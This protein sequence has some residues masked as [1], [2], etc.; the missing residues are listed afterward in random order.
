MNRSLTIGLGWSS[1]A[2]TRIGVWSPKDMS[3]NKDVSGTKGV[4]S[5]RQ[6]K[7]ENRL[8]DAPGQEGRLQGSTW[9]I[10]RLSFSVFIVEVVRA[11]YTLVNNHHIIQ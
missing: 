4:S 3:K 2:S 1:A 5:E 7:P 9:K 8:T 6:N 10:S 11:L